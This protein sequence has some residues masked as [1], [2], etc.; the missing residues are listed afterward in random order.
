MLG[1]LVIPSVT[2]YLDKAKASEAA[3]ETQ[4][5]L[6]AALAV[7]EQAGGCDPLLGTAGPTPP[8]AVECHAGDGGRCRPVEGPGEGP[9]EY[10][11]TAWSED[12]IWT[13]LDYQPDRLGTGSHRY[14]YALNGERAGDGCRL[15]VQAFGDLDADGEFSTYE[16]EATIGADGAQTILPMRVEGEDE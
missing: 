11:R 5:I 15:R 9:G 12:P 10:P 1:V 6:T 4:A 8:L 3:R 13:A 16:R 7:R 14:H 2:G